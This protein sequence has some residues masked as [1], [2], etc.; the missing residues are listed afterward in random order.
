MPSIVFN[1]QN[2]MPTHA[3]YGEAFPGFRKES[4]DGDL[5]IPAVASM[6]PWLPATLLGRASYL[7]ELAGPQRHTN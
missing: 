4:F 7:L 5:L 6:F 3:L 2:G 1:Y